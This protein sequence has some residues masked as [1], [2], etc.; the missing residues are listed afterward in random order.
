MKSYRKELVFNVP[1]RRDFINNT[2]QIE[3]IETRLKIKL[4]LWFRNQTN[5]V[6]ADYYLYY[7]EHTNKHDG[8]FIFAQNAPANSDYK[9]GHNQK[10]CK[11]GTIEQNYRPFR[12]IIQK[13]PILG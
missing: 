11:G 6:Y 13:L 4:S 3:E 5:D 7:Q 10:V 12:P 2:M 8:G 1:Q 9:L